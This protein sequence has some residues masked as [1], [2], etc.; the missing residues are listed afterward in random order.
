MLVP[1]MTWKLEHIKLLQV[2]DAKHHLYRSLAFALAA[3]A[4]YVP[5]NLY[6]FMTMRHSGRLEYTTIWDGIQSL[7][8]SGMWITATIVFMA[9]III[10]VFKLVSLIFIIIAYNYDFARDARWTLLALIEFI[11]RWSMLDVFIVAIMVALVKFGSFATV[12]ADISSYLFGFV[13]IL[14]MLSSAT[15]S[16]YF[17]KVIL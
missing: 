11:G 13:V 8:N 9:S 7:Y 1:R 12:T 5:A 2:T 4:L 17:K 6:P 14:T 15:L 16:M 10:P 3:L